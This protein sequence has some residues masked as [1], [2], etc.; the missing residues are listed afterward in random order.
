MCV[1]V[2]GSVA[3]L[4]HTCGNSAALLSFSSPPQIVSDTM[5]QPRDV[6]IRGRLQFCGR[7]FRCPCWL[8]WTAA[9][10]AGAA[11]VPRGQ[12]IHAAAVSPVVTSRRQSSD[13]AN[14]F[15]PPL[16]AIWRRS[17]SRPP[18]AFQRR[19]EITRESYSIARL[20]GEEAKR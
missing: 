16:P 11:F 19:P 18:R 17:T 10:A 5:E 7:Y 14:A 15:S 13:G 2:S 3:G 1:C 20:T 4:V 6:D 12:W 9:A 8:L